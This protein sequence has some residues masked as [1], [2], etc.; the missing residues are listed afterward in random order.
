MCDPGKWCSRSSGK[1]NISQVKEDQNVSWRGRQKEADMLSRLENQR[2]EWL[3]QV[4]EHRLD[5]RE[6]SYM[7]PR[8]L[9]ESLLCFCVL[10]SYLYT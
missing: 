3:R 9:L 6:A 10:E 7:S 2:Q 5:L 4:Q 1:G 8:N